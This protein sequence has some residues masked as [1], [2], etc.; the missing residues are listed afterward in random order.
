MSTLRQEA[1]EHAAEWPRGGVEKLD[2]VVVVVGGGAAR[3]G[4]ARRDTIVARAA[5]LSLDGADHGAIGAV[6]MVAFWGAAELAS[7]LSSS[8]PMLV[9]FRTALGGV[10]AVA[11]AASAAESQRRM[12][13]ADKGARRRSRRGAP[14]V[15]SGSLPGRRRRGRGTARP[16]G[17]A[18]PSCSWFPGSRPLSGRAQLLGERCSTTT[19][20][21]GLAGC[22]DS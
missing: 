3:R 20:L 13:R 15:A 8:Y 18:V 14:G 4:A 5:V 1:G 9:V 6:T 7:A 19:S 12:A 22:A 10:T 17:R 16:V 11:A 21:V 2:R